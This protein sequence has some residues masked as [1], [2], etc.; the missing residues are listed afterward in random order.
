MADIVDIRFRM[1]SGEE[2]VALYD[3]VNPRV[4]AAVESGRY[5]GLI[6]HTCERTDDGIRI[7][8]VWED[9]AQWREMYADPNVIEGMKAL[10]IPEP[11]VEIRPLHNV[12]RGRVAGSA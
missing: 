5:P 1:G 9:A 2:A 4:V 8:D 12:E 10:G 6:V 11:E 3:R 7:V